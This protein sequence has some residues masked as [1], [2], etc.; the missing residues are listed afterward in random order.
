MAQS[1]TTPQD[2]SAS[3]PA[4]P[5]R[6]ES[7]ER[8]KPLD[9]WRGISILLVLAC[10]LVP[11]G[12]KG[13][14][15]NEAA[16]LA[17]MAIFFTLSGFLITSMLYRHMDVKSFFIR[18]ACRIL[19]LALVYITVVLLIV[20]AAP[21]M[22]AAHYTFLQTYWSQTF[23]QNYWPITETPKITGHLWS[24][25]TE[26][27][28]YV[29]IGLLCLVLRRW[30]FYVLPVVC[31]AIT[32]LRI[33]HGKGY[34]VITHERVDEILAGACLALVYENFLRVGIRR[35]LSITLL[36]PVLLVLFA[37]SCHP[38]FLEQWGAPLLYVRPYMAAALV[39]STL[40]IPNVFQEFLKN[41]VLAYIATISYALYVIHIGAMHGWLGSGGTLEKYA[42]RPLVIAITWILAHL[43]TFYFEAWWIKLGKKWTAD[44]KHERA[45]GESKKL[46][47]PQ[48]PAT[49]PTPEAA[50]VSVGP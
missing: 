32:A 6:A 23:L 25:C 4:A 46:D 5:L 42:K 36:Q 11:L 13:S 26:I 1:L 31:I 12:W 43:S 41:R 33:Y 45:P 50:T 2:K 48:V 44:R 14:G 10:H 37:L 30:A 49:P 18:R 3:A 22:F 9:G 21:R 17:G 8:L 15:M 20:G 7:S 28:F 39:G 16:G 24:L 19:P 38:N 34:S 27:Q 40:L 35:V 29:F 47:H